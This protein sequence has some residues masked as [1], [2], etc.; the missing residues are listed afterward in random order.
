MQG[1]QMVIKA[2]QDIG[3]RFVFGYTGGAIMP[4]LDEMEKE[5]LFLLALADHLSDHASLNRDQLLSIND[6]YAIDKDAARR[7]LRFY[8]KKLKEEFSNLKQPLSLPLESK[9]LQTTK[10]IA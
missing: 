4:V 8:R 10:K 2:L 5:K 9:E 6:K 3:T 7:D 1:T